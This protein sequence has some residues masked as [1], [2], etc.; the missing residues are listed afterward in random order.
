MAIEVRQIT[1]VDELGLLAAQINGASWDADNDI[2]GDYSAG[3]L[4]NYLASA[5]NL[6]VAAYMDDGATLAGL[7]S[8]RVA[9]KPYGD[10]KWLYIDEVDTCASHRR[11]G[12]GRALMVSLLRLAQ[13]HGCG[14]V[15]LGTE[16]YNIAANGLYRSLIPDSVD[17]VVGYTFRP[18]RDSRW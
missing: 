6:L 18:G 12:V 3:S 17:E 9:L 10:V 4:A 2:D 11:R 7:A 8:A 13:Q 16:P 1:L 14:E 5:D 15:W